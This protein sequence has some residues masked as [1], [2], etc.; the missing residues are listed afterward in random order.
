MQEAHFRQRFHPFHELKPKCRRALHTLI[1]ERGLRPLPV[2][3][4]ALSNLVWFARGV[5]RLQGAE[6]LGMKKLSC[7]QQMFY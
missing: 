4:S 7:V 2:S 6:K 3:T 5:N 1:F